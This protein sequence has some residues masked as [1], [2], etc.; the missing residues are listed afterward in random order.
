MQQRNWKVLPKDH[1]HPKDAAPYAASINPQGTISISHRTWLNMGEPA[2]VKILYDDLTHCLGL[3][4]TG[5]EEN[6][7]YKVGKPCAPTRARPIY[8]KRLITEW[9]INIPDVLSF[10]NPEPDPYGVLILNL[11]T[12]VV[13]KR[14]LRHWRRK[15]ERGVGEW[16]SG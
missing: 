12:A 13:S 3:E 16:V 9:G 11:R 2:A 15:N 14:A 4:V 5:L 8:A 10:V 7:A 1:L 6:N